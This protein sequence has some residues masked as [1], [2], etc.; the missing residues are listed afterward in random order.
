MRF[1]RSEEKKIETP[2]PNCENV[3]ELE[4]PKEPG[5]GSRLVAKDKHKKKA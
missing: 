5:H 1:A 2:E 3:T 4:L